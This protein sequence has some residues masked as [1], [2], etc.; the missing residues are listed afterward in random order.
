MD[1]LAARHGV[2]LIPHNSE[3]IPPDG[4]KPSQIDIMIAGVY[5]LGY[6][7]LAPRPEV[8]RLL[9]WWADRLRRD[10]RVDPIWGYFVD[11]RWF[12]LAPGFLTDLAIVRDPECNVA[13][14][15]LQDRRLEHGG[16]SYLVDGRPLAFFH[17]S[18]FD[19]EHPLVLSRH[20]NRVDVLEHPVLEQLLAKYAAEVIAEG[21]TASRGWPYSYGAMGDGTRLDETIRSL[22][23]DYADEH[24]DVASPFTLEGARS[25][26]GWLQ[27]QA[28]GAPPGITRVLARGETD[29]S[30]LRAPAEEPS[31]ALR[32]APWGVNVVCDFRSELEI[33]AVARQLV[34]ALDAKAIPA[35][36][37]L[38]PSTELSRHSHVYATAAPRDAPFPVNLI[39]LDPDVLPEFPNHLGEEF[40]AGRYSVG[41]WFW[42]G[43]RVPERW[44][45]Y[46]SLVDEVWAPTAYVAGALEPLAT[47]S[48]NTIRIPVE[49]IP[50]EPRSRNALGLPDQKFLFHS[51]F[52]DQSGFE[53]SNPL[54][55]I[56]A[57]RR[58]FAPGEGACLLLYDVAAQRDRAVYAELR[59]AAA[60]H[61][62][63]DLIDRDLP[64]LDNK[65]LTVLSDC[66]VSLHRAE[67]FGMAMAEAMWLGKP[68]IATGYSGNLD[69][70]TPENSYLVDHRLVPIGPG[71]DPYSADGVW[72]DPDVEHAA[73]LMRQVFDDRAAGR[74]RGADG[75]QEIRRTHA[76][77]VAGE[78]LWRRLE[79][80]R[81]TGRARSAADPMRGRPPALAELPLRIRQGP[82]GAAVGGRGGSAR[83]LMRKAIL[84]LIG[85]YAAYQRTINAEVVAG[86]SE[87]GSAIADLRREAAA[88]RAQ[89]MAEVRRT[90]RQLG[91]PR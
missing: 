69:F 77:E 14:W 66:Y 2:V 70:M 71:H 61:P 35:L 42:E 76:L 59:E 40:L 46:L 1:E 9:D 19:P 32:P 62:D 87:L 72:A 34:A 26:Q 50:L 6:V 36:P 18:G 12:D 53:R 56:E 4:R 89:R 3:P 15:N 78:I 58:A 54:A 86:L 5:N 24:G 8:E 33:G 81:A 84:R 17:F 7:S 11:Q 49:P 13:Y 79:S 85:P 48:V 63:I 91:S 83:E 67:A 90:E 52:D 37:I 41:L 21:H 43:S 73:M 29:R 47:A 68:V 55:V 82:T 16:G 60:D 44:R 22:Y 51:S 25:F 27:G 45:A 20:Q 30:D 65:S 39:C 57:F 10:C 31:A 80:I 23:D 64:P 88:E 28:P 38:S 75:A 74:E